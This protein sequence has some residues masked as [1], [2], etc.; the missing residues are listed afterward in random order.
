MSERTHPSRIELASSDGASLLASDALDGGD[1][2]DTLTVYS[3]RG[4]TVDLAA[5]LAAEGLT[6]DTLASFERVL[7]GDG[8]DTLL[9]SER[10]EELSG[11][12]GDDVLDG[13][14]GDDVVDGGSGRD[15]VRG[16]DGNDRLRPPPSRAGR[17]RMSSTATSRPRCRPTASGS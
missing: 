6:R 13:R 9:G 4:F 8:P 2:K 5:G 15:R 10:G 17:E 11:G 12:S 16:G 1:G 3:A 7:G 14:G